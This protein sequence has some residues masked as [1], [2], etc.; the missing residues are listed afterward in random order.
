MRPDD[1]FGRKCFADDDKITKD[2][3]LGLVPSFMKA[4]SQLNHSF[5]LSKEIS[6]RFFNQDNI[7]GRLDLYQKSKIKLFEDKISG[8]AEELERLIAKGCEDYDT[9]LFNEYEQFSKDIDAFVQGLFAGR[10]GRIGVVE[11]VLKR[12]IK[13]SLEQA[14]TKRDDYFKTMN[15]DYI[16]GLLRELS[17]AVPLGGEDLDDPINQE[18]TNNS[19]NPTVEYKK[20]QFKS[21]KTDDKPTNL[22]SVQGLLREGTVND[23]TAPGDGDEV[24]HFNQQ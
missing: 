21:K 13:P 20:I 16:E 18:L 1:N 4:E 10:D 17:S 5:S 2:R 15:N 6:S 19:T 11:E 24:S 22:G 9:K 12:N 8:L 14:K 3:L 23:N 7:K